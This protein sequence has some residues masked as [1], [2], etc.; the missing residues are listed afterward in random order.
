MIAE[1]IKIKTVDRLI[2]VVAGASIR[3]ARPDA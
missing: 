2:N 1:V 3:S